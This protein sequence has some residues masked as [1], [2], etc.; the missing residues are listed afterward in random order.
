MKN[1]IWFTFL[2]LWHFVV[3][4]SQ[5][6]D[7]RDLMERHQYH[8]VINLLRGRPQTNENLRLM[9]TCHE[10]MY[11]FDDALKMYEIL[12][13]SHPQNI[14]LIIAAAESAYSAGDTKKSLHYW[15]QANELDT[16][17]LYLQTNKALAH[18]RAEDWSGVVISCE[19][20]FETDT[21][22]MLLRIMGDASEHLNND[23]AVFFYKKAIEKNPA[24]YLSVRNLCDYYYTSEIYDSVKI[25]SDAYLTK[26]DSTQKRI[27]QYNGMAHYATRDY[28]KAIERL[29][30]NMALGDSTYTTAYFL[31]MS[32]FASKHYYDAVLPFEIA[33]NQAPKPEPM[34]LYYYGTAL[35]KAYDKKRGI[36]I[37][38]QGV[39]LIEKTNE[40]LYDFNR[41]LAYAYQ[42]SNQPGKSVQ[43]YVK[44]YDKRPENKILLYF[45]AQE[46][47]KMKD[48]K[49][50][51]KYYE[52]FLKTYPKD[53]KALSFDEIKENK[54]DISM[55]EVY[56]IHAKNRLQQLEEDLFFKG[57]E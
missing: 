4:N 41:S 46:Y 26:I 10:K 44:A 40:G 31:G 24:D 38:L 17:N 22:P 53:K 12:L 7:A 35:S 45:I 23:K 52:R 25:I 33:Y 32:R 28:K 15:T 20:I 16:N 14:G 27:G 50:A 55:L 6:D 39:E 13:V 11:E 5:I 2:I 19:K 51:L 3:C 9:A 1:K 18:Y 8:E 37:L 36:E 49:N 57:D 47:D 30:K 29:E 48:T 42:T 21:I 43:Y 54:G 34:L 56:F